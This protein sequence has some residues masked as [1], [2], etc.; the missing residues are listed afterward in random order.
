MLSIA[1]DWEFWDLKHSFTTAPI[2]GHPD[3]SR[4]FVVENDALDVGVGAVLSQHSALDLKLHPCTF[5][6]HSLNTTGRGFTMWGIGSFSR[7]RWH[8]GNGSTGS[9]GDCVHRPQK[10]GVSLH[11]QVPQL[12]AG[13]MGPTV[14]PVKLFPLLLAGVQNIKPDALSCHYNPT[15]TSPEPETIL[16]TMC[17]VTAHS[18]G[19]G[20]FRQ[21]CLPPGRP[22]IVLVRQ[23][24]WWP[25]MVP[26]VAIFIADCDV[27]AWNKSPQQAPACLLQPLPVPHLHWPHISLDYFMGHPPSDGNTAILTML[28]RFFKAIHFIPFPKLLS[29]KET[30][31]LMVQHVFQIH[32]LTVDKVSDCGA[33]Y[34]HTLCFTCLCD[35]LYLRPGVAHLP[36][37]PL[38]I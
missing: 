3:P 29:A 16:P 23:R 35:C 32:G 22:P 8:W 10:P 11:R 28:D 7:R 2:L 19:V 1:A 33:Q 38:C 34:C 31:Q 17:L 15:A 4:Q 12:Q 36:H 20:P 18:S 30:A 13:E 24:F 25:T 9:K 6:S 27:C 26:D 37:Y 5:F 21:A 14:Y